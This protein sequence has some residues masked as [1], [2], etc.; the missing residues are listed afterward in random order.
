MKFSF[1]HYDTGKHIQAADA[2]YTMSAF[3]SLVWV[4]LYEHSPTSAYTFDEFSL[5]EKEYHEAEC[6]EQRFQNSISYVTTKSA[7]LRNA[8]NDKPQMNRPELVTLSVK[9]LHDF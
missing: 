9:V 5:G 8:S 1:F 6:A 7:D 2:M 4:Q 3:N